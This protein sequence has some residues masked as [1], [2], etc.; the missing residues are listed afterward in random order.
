MEK[1]LKPD[2]IEQISGDSLIIGWN[3]GKQCLYNV[4]I[5]RAKCPCAVCRDEREN[6]NPLKVLNINQD[7]FELKTW[8]MIGNY[9]IALEWGDDHDTGIYTYTFLR[10]LCED[11]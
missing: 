2:H 11:T 5:L 8:K 1:Q 3:D 4:K 7:S 6:T 9:A 10:E